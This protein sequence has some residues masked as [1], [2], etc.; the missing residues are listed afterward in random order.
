MP[1]RHKTAWMP[2]ATPPPPRTTKAKAHCGSSLSRA[3]TP[4]LPVAAAVVAVPPLSKSAGRLNPLHTKKPSAAGRGLFTAAAFRPAACPAS[5]SSLRAPTYQDRF[6]RKQ[7]EHRR[8]AAT[9]DSLS[10]FSRL[11]AKRCAFCPSARD[12]IRVCSSQFAGC[13]GFCTPR[14]LSPDVHALPAALHEPRAPPGACR[15][16]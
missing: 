14:R 9:S 1:V 16:S 10:G 7:A 12:T 4:L 15:Q 6:I 13:F 5:G 8:P 11:V 2:Y 3:V